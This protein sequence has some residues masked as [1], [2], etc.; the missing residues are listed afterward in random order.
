MSNRLPGKGKNKAK[1]KGDPDSVHRYGFDRV[2]GRMGLVGKTDEQ[3]GVVGT[4]GLLG[5]IVKRLEGTGDLELA[6]QR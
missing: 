1:L 6:T 2:Y 3:G 5:V 4:A